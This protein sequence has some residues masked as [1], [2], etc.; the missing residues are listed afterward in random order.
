PGPMAAD[1]QNLTRTLHRA[2]AL[3]VLALTAL[4]GTLLWLEVRDTVPASAA[5]REAVLPAL[6][7]FFSLAT[8]LELAAVW[9]LKRQIVEPLTLAEQVASRVS[10]G[11]LTAVDLASNGRHTRGG[12]LLTSVSGMVGALREMTGALQ[13]AATDVADMVQE[14]AARPV[15]SSGDRADVAR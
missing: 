3:A 14:N 8:A 12:R 9:W 1:Q 10:R 7:G 2:G 5:A 15:V 6:I 4:V 11:D 13:N